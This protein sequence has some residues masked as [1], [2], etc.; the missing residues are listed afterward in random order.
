MDLWQIKKPA[1]QHIDRRFYTKTVYA[2]VEVPATSIH[3][4]SKRLKCLA[5]P[6]NGELYFLIVSARNLEERFV[7]FSNHSQITSA[8]S[9]IILTVIFGLP[10]LSTTTSPT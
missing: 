10:E 5:V 2:Y 7:V 9:L 8:E 6:G 4:L 3:T 1:M